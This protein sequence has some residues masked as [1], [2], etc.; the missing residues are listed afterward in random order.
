MWVLTCT[1]AG[2]WGGTL[3]VFLYVCTDID[4][5]YIHLLTEPL[6]PLVH[7]VSDRKKKQ[8]ALKKGKVAGKGSS[9]TLASESSDAENAFGSTTQLAR[10]VEDLELNDRSCTG[11]L[12]SHPQSRD[13]H[14]QS[15]TL[16]FH[17]H[18]IL[19]DADLELNYGR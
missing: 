19:T 8:A 2:A 3:C 18:E 12:T 7:R 13:I 5:A 9:A 10:D 16:L 17:G 15:F 6:P 4:A 1:E 14:F 11:I